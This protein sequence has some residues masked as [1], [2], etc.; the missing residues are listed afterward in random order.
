MS[1]DVIRP[2]KGLE[3][4]VF[5]E[6]KISK[7]M[8]DKKSLMYRG[9]WV[10]E[11]A[12][13]CCFEEIAYLLWHGEL[14]T[15][16]QLDELSQAER[17]QRAIS[18]ALT[19]AIRLFP[20]T[21][22]PMDA[23]RTG[24]SFLGMEDENA[25]DNDRQSNERKALSLMA[26]IPT[27][28]AYDYRIKNG[29]EPIAP[30][31]DLTFSE[32]FFNMCFGEVPDKEVVKAFDVSLILYAEHGFNASTFTARVVASTLSEM[33]AA[34]TA[35]IGSLKGPLHGGANEQVMHMLKEIGS[36]E[37][38]KAWMLDALQNKKK[39]MGFGHRLYRIGDS[40]VPT[41]SKYRDRLAEITGNKSWV[42]MSHILEET[43]VA[44]KGIHPNLDFPAGPAYYMMGFDIEMFTP[45]FVMARVTGWSAHVMEQL[46]NNRLVR[47][48]SDYK[49]P[50][51]RS[52]QPIAQRG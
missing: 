7:A 48:L 1:A 18:P 52:P 2:K 29:K 26:K 3:G 39:V 22:H 33:Y 46:E 51:P 41:M 47:P 12:E 15:Q 44:E 32:N 4:V 5:D 45:I 28:I 30:K 36:A 9:Y 21:A 34:V 14:P 20:K 16:A 38:A 6:S 43:M 31:S 19:E 27:I 50:G 11:L 42:E 49:G 35:A 25:W 10:H 37:N 40:R 17:S 8:P 23:I 24:V 13:T